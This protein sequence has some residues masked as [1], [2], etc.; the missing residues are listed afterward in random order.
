MNDT[1]KKIEK[2]NDILKVLESTISKNKAMIEMLE[3]IEEQE[4]QDIQALTFLKELL[5][6]ISK[7]MKLSL[8]IVNI[9]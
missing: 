4:E 9:Y 8:N 2:V 6:K 1:E 5:Q 3:K 7:S